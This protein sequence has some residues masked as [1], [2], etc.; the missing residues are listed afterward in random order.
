MGVS[1]FF[2]SELFR[3]DFRKVTVMDSFIPEV[4]DPDFAQHIK[5]WSPMTCAA[6]ASLLEIWVRQLRNRSSRVRV[7][8]PKIGA[9]KNVA[10]N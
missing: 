4:L 10:V 7:P 3:T 9:P 6:V 8:C 1:R 5:D 2:L